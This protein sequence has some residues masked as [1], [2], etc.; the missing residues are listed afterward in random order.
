MKTVVLAA[1]FGAWIVVSC[2]SNDA[3]DDAAPATQAPTAEQV[4]TFV[5]AF[6]AIVSTCC[7][8]VGSPLDTPTC[9]NHLYG[10]GRPYGPTSLNVP[11][12]VANYDPVSGPA[13][14]EDLQ[15]ALGG[16]SC[17]PWSADESSPCWHIFDGHYGS[18][19]PG[20]PCA[21]NS[22]CTA[23]AGGTARCTFTSTSGSTKICVW[24]TYGKPGDGPCAFDEVD[25]V[26]SDAGRDVVPKTTVCRQ[27][28]GVSCNSSTGLCAPLGGPGASCNGRGLE[29]ASRSCDGQQCR[30]SVPAGQSCG[31]VA[32]ESGAYCDSSSSTCVASLPP[33]TAC[34]SDAQCSENACTGGACSALTPV[35]R[36]MLLAYGCPVPSLL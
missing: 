22:D 12:V 26:I 15:K 10:T 16:S 36:N 28:D 33:G 3:V 20:S 29:C 23:P 21:T 4:S 24:L 17:F 34:T 30:A 32:C 18:V 9:R 31:T 5:D 19:P 13:C 8:R 7:T 27:I 11:P 25:G 2:G 35:Q 14:L 6:C 1:G